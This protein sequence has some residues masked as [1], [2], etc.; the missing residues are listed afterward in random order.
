[1]N[2][3]LSDIHIRDPFVLPEPAEGK[4][5]MYG[6]IGETCWKGKPRGF[7]VYMSTDLVV[8][9]GPYPAFRPAPDFWSDFNYW[10]PEVHEWQG[11]Y[12]MFATFKAD[13]RCR[14]TQTLVAEGPLGPF[15]PLG[16]GPLTPRD[17]ECLDGTFYVDRHGEPWMVFSH[18]WVQVQDGEICAVRLSREL[19]RAVSEPVLLFRASEA[20][21]AEGIRGGA[22]YVTD[23][24]FLY[25]AGT[26][27]LL[28]LWSSFSDGG[29]TIGCA[30]QAEDDI[31]GSWVQ[32]A[33]PLYKR[34]GGHGM[35]FRTFAGELRLAIHTPNDSPNERPIFIPVEERGG[36]LSAFPKEGGM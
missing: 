30:R 32:D 13:G 20:P 11:R 1:M 6:T 18:E 15:R 17:W 29:Y 9:E 34:D 31:D 16:D 24:P 23:G 33:E 26:G 25:R 7:D 12:Y 14:G 5:Y 8:W 27:E 28:L 19:D 22:N 4:Y 10:A 21:W 2:L 3:M 35:V 36:R